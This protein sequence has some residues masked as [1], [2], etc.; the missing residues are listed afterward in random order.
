MFV[1]QRAAAAAEASGVAWQ[2]VCTTLSYNSARARPVRRG[3][4]SARSRRSPAKPCG[5]GF[6]GCTCNIDDTA[7]CFVDYRWSILTLVPC[8]VSLFFL[9]HC[10]EDNTLSI[11]VSEKKGTTW[12]CCSRALGPAA[13]HAPHRSKHDTAPQWRRRTAFASLS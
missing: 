7:A 2:T 3:H 13:T 9:L 12:Y 11:A 1:A 4:A 8:P 10:C 5:G 6:A